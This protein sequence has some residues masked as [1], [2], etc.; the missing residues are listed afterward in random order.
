MWTD[1]SS[2]IILTAS[3]VRDCFLSIYE[4]NISMPPIPT[5]SVKNAWLIAAN[6]T[7]DIPA[8]LALSMSG[9]R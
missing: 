3:P 9:T 5:E 2:A 1:V 7:S 8:S 4:P 6:S